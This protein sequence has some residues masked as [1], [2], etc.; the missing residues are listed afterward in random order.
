MR[1]LLDGGTADSIPIEYMRRIG[2]EKN[3]VVLTRPEGYMKRPEKTMKT[4]STKI[5]A[6]FMWQILKKMWMIIL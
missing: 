2:Y 3:I 1:G 4:L 6:P 5:Q